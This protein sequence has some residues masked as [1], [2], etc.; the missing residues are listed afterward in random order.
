[1]IKVLI[2]TIGSFV[3]TFLLAPFIINILYRFQ[4]REAIRK[5]GPQ[6]HLVKEGTPTMAGILIII[7]VSAVNLFFNLSRAETYLPIFALITAGFLGILEDI[8]K[9]HRKSFLINFFRRSVVA[10]SEGSQSL[11]SK[12]RSFI[13]S[14]WRI[15]KEVFRALGSK[16]DIGLKSYQKFLFQAAIGTFLA[17]WFY[18]KLD[19]NTVWLPLLGDV[20]IGFLYPVF[21]VLIF[22]FFLNSVGVTDGLDGLAGGLLCLLFASLGSVALIQNQ[23]GLAIFC[24]TV[25]GS[26]LAFL[27]FNFYPA[28]V[29]MGNVGSHA[30]GATAAVVAMMLHKEFILLI[31]GGVFV[32][33]MVSVILQVASVKL[34][35]R[36]VFRMA[37]IHHHFELSGWPETKVTMRFWLLGTFFSL[38]GVLLSIVK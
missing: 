14:P 5:D 33:E 18:F 26:L 21:I 12:I 15:F 29:F 30:L 4:I 27:Y 16:D 7:A 34:Y 38:L 3:F 6:S 28:R 31:M 9:I 37:P 13:S 32:M 1:M 17:L 20:N 8:F 23:I 24:S 35:G 2:F 10:R 11:L 22:T 25:V 36:R 19:W